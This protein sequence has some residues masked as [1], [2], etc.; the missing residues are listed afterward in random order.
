MHVL[1]AFDCRHRWFKSIQ[2]KF[3]LR[4]LDEPNS[5][6]FAWHIYNLFLLF[7]FHRHRGTSECLLFSCFRYLL[8]AFGIYHIVVVCCSTD[9]VNIRGD[10]C[11]CID[12]LSVR[13]SFGVDSLVYFIVLCGHLFHYKCIVKWVDN[14]KRKL[15]KWKNRKNQPILYTQRAHSYAFKSLDN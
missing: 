7:S 9:C 10:N 6:A 13:L 8:H 2:M 15:N 1:P 14:E 11:V 4:I 12:L 5:N 3:Q